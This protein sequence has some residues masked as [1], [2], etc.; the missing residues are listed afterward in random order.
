MASD[1]H[2][3]RLL[4]AILMF[5]VVAGGVFLTGRLA[6]WVLKTIL[7]PIIAILMGWGAARFVYRTRD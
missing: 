1:S 7:L 4:P 6:T 2:R 5:I 3:G